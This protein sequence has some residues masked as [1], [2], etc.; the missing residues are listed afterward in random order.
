VQLRR[1]TPPIDKNKAAQHVLK[2]PSQFGRG[3]KLGGEMLAIQIEQSADTTV[4][5]LTGSA[6]G[7]G[8]LGVFD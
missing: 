2:P 3:D 4:N 6:C 7:F 8:G 1:G 5:R